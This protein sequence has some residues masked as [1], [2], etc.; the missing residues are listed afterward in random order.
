MSDTTHPDR[1]VRA[2]IDDG[3][4]G[5]WDW[6]IGPADLANGAALVIRVIRDDLVMAW[7]DG[8]VTTLLDAEKFLNDRITV[9]SGRPTT[10]GDTT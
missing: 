4:T 7:Q 3:W 5:E 9:L 2:L 10:S 1:A 6:P 8:R